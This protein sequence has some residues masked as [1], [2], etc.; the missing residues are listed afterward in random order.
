LG[1]D[2]LER[3]ETSKFQKS[4]KKIKTEPVALKSSSLSPWQGTSPPLKSPEV[5]LELCLLYI[6]FVKGLPLYLH[7]KRGGSFKKKCA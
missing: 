1:D 3:L 4:A 5:K 7:E 2:R 6:I